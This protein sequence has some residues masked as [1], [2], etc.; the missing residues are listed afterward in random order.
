MENICLYCG[1]IET[2]DT[3][4]SING[5]FK[6]GYCNYCYVL[7]VYEEKSFDDRFEP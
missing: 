3:T 2:F 5:P 7:V 6:D 1:E 4:G